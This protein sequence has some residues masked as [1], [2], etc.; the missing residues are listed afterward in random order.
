M[1]LARPHA[2]PG[3]AARTA[4]FSGTCC[5]LLNGLS[6]LSL[7]EAIN[8]A[9]QKSPN[10]L[11][12]VLLAW[13]SRHLSHLLTSR[14]LIRVGNLEKNR[15]RQKLFTFFSATQRPRGLV[16]DLLN[17]T[18]RI[19]QVASVQAAYA[20]LRLAPLFFIVVFL[21]GGWLSALIA[22]T[23]VVLSV[24]F[25]IKAG[26]LAEKYGEEY[27]VT[28]A[29]FE[30]R[31]LQVLQAGQELR[32][33]GAGAFAAD[34]ISALSEREHLSALKAVGAALQSSLVTEFLSG[35]GIGLVAMVCGFALLGARTTLL[36]ALVAIFFTNE[37]FAS[38]RRFG[39]EFHQS[40]EAEKAILTFRAVQ[41]SEQ[42]TTPLPA[43]ANVVA[44]PGRRPV[45]LQLAPGMRVW[46]KGH[47]GSGKTALL[48]TMLGLRQPIEGTV[49]KGSVS[50]AYVSP[51]ET[52]FSGTL[53]ENLDPS[54]VHGDLTLYEALHRVNL[55]SARFNS[56][57]ARLG[58]NGE[59]LSSGELVRFL[60]AR[61][62]VAQAELFVLDDI[63]GLLDEAHKKPLVACLKSLTKACLVE[64]ST[65][66][67]LITPSLTIEVAK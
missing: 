1:N 44:V 49:S 42:A 62:I 47:S 37:L 54:G 7:A 16:G 24:P 55:G 52:L 50:I 38:V 64:A 60:V 61:G 67:P 59:G 32:G 58:P 46:I 13:A 63:A 6:A 14:V 29:D 45:T 26:R 9:T 35:V 21:S 30:L 25:Y 4:R 2:F 66:T 51:S 18:D 43:L 34:E 11:A 41:Q 28:L 22:A 57:S 23:L 31:Q 36:R 3:V 15:A 56:L 19:G 8:S 40:Q 5:A 65:T 10:F 33:L 53:R 17:D 48:E 20:G 12:F 27:E 39:S